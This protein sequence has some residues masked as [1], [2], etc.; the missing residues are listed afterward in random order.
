MGAEGD[1]LPTSAI[2]TLGRRGPTSHPPSFPPSPSPSPPP[3]V[4]G[5]QTQMEEDLTQAV[6]VE[7]LVE[8]EED[9]R[10]AVA[11]EGGGKGEERY[12]LFGKCITGKN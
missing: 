7:S 11:A 4:L 1:F 9:S 12:G 10:Q 6:V 2:T 8:V 5:L 3:V